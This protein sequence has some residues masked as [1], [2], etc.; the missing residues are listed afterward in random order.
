[1]K[2]KRFNEG[3]INHF[4]DD[5]RSFHDDENPYNATPVD[6]PEPVINIVRSEDGDWAGL[7]ID[8]QLKTEG[9]SITS[10]DVLDALGLKFKVVTMNE[11]EFDYFGSRCPHEYKD[12][13]DTLKA[14]KKRMSINPLTNENDPYNEEVWDEKPKPKLK[15]VDDFFN[16]RA[17]GIGNV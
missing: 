2:I 7:Y 9:H 14:R 4:M 8:G 16:K 5:E 3:I 10:S 12:V 13:K 11:T 6:K 1:M 17:F 15:K